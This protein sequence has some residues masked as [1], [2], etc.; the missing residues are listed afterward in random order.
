MDKHQFVTELGKLR[1]ASTFLTLRGYRNEASEI[2]DYSIAFHFS[3]ENALK[4]SIEKLA[5]LD[6]QTALEKQARSE[7]IDSFAR[8][9]AK[10]AGSPEL[11]ER[12]PTYTYFKGD[13]GN[14]IKGVKYHDGKD[15]LYLYGLVVHKRV[16]MPGL[17]DKKNRKEL[18]IAKDKLRYLT[19][20]GKFR[21]FK[22]NS[23]QVD[24]ISVEGLHLL[25]PESG[26]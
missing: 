12:D 23:F 16:L 13:D 25:P 3:Y 8:S 21:S 6:L 14:Y 9:L 18:T 17:Y 7:L 2:A 24:S 22:I 19:P 26:W 15:E 4:K 5:A 11:E 10:G 1:P 20:V